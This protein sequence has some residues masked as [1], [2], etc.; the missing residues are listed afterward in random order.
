MNSCKAVQWGV[1]AGIIYVLTKYKHF[2]HSAMFYFLLFCRVLI[3][4]NTQDVSDDFLG[5]VIIPLHS[6]MA[7]EGTARF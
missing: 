7:A 3:N 6:I 5:R 4:S 1:L 2:S